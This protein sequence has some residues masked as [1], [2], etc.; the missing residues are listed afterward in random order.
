MVVQADAAGEEDAVV[1]AGEEGAAEQVDEMEVSA[2]LVGAAEL[3]L[4]D[5]G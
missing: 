4:G 3:A 5:V 2:E 1:W